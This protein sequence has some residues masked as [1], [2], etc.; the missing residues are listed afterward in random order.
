MVATPLANCRDMMLARQPGHLLRYLL[1]T[2]RAR[3][4]DK[5][6]CGPVGTKCGSKIRVYD[7]YL[8][9]IGT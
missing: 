5:D 6:E 4:A 2:S 3:E 7:Q 1:A 9:S 8:C